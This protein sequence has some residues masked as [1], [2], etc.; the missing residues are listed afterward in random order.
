MVVNKHDLALAASQYLAG[1]IS[2]VGNAL[3][4]KPEAQ[5]A[6]EKYNLRVVDLSKVDGGDPLRHSTFIRALPALDRMIQ[7]PALSGSSEASGMMRVLAADA[8]GQILRAPLRLGQ[9]LIRR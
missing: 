5:A 7:S 1:E 6:I 4:D 2:R 3:I 9:S 8:A